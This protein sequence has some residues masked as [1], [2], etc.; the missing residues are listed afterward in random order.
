M[1]HQNKLDYRV[2]DEL[3]HEKIQIIKKLK[4]KQNIEYV[5]YYIVVK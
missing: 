3:Q 5:K 4:I 2:P 1:F